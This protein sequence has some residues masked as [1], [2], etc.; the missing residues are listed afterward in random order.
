MWNRYLHFC[1]LKSKTIMFF[2][3]LLPKESRKWSTTQWNWHTENMRV[4]KIL[5]SWF[6]PSQNIPFLSGQ[7]RKA[8]HW[9]CL[10]LEKT[11]IEMPFATAALI[12]DL[13]DDSFL[14]AMSLFAKVYPRWH[15]PRVFVARL[16]ILKGLFAWYHLG[17]TQLNSPLTG[18]RLYFRERLFKHNHIPKAAL[19]VFLPNV[20][21]IHL[22]SFKWIFFQQHVVFG[23]KSEARKG[24]TS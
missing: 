5:P 8:L 7:K 14:Y 2:G 6:V 4:W 20:D 24:A 11:F 22:A 17:R 9:K 3:A 16:L 10:H 18:A 19:H 1:L 13:G 15:G 23:S 12:Q 21:K